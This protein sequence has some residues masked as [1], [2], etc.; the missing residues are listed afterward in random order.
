MSKPAVRH[1]RLTVGGGV[2][3]LGLAVTLSLVTPSA[4][5]A[6]TPDHNEGFAIIAD[7]LN[8]PRGLSPAP[9]G[10]L[11]LAE[12][13]SG[14]KVCVSGGEHG[15]TCIGRT[16][17]FDLVTSHGVKRIVTGLISASGPGGVAAEG[18]VSVSRGPDGTLYGLFGLN[19]HEVPPKGAIPAKLRAAALAQLGRLVRV[20]PHH[21]IRYV[22]DVGDQDW[23]WT[24][25][26]VNLAPKDF[27]D[28]NPN[29]VLYSHGHRYVVDAGANILVDVQRN[30][31][32]K[33]LA[34]FGVPAGSQSDAVPTCVARGPDGALYVGELLGGFYSPGHARIW[35]VVPGHAPR[36]WATG[37][38]TVQGCGFGRD[39]AFYATEYQ[40][41]GLNE[42]PGAN[43]AG[44]VVR[45]DRH[46]HRTHL[47]IGKLFLP[48][49][50]AAGPDG[51][52]Y[53]S[54]C[55]IAPASGMGPKLCP[56]GGQVVRIG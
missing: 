10:G 37:L 30:G 33:V 54:N 28:A 35:R 6:Q 39:G 26:R 5:G 43:P 50:F 14:G 51:A 38:S 12:A 13:G 46:G 44:D 34:F 22:S 17:S 24:S 36:V 15:D 48:S 2:I 27:P 20:A 7:H 21:S 19:S 4:A 40:V 56:T 9:G 41:A 49:G 32:A 47:G 3:A 18:P 23:T 42:G 55:S 52:I 45:I 16:G 53:V 1:R 25:T 31:T 8:N 11:Y 29:A